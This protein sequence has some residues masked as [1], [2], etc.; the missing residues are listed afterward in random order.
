MDFTFHMSKTYVM[1][2]INKEQSDSRYF[3][4]Y[5]RNK[6]YNAEGKPGWISVDYSIQHSGPN[7][8][9]YSEINHQEKPLFN[10]KTW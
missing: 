6:Y 8:Q 5:S 3:D 10:S 9:C 1:P 7:M 4:F 2:W